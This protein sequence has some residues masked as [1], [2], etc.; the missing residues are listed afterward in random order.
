MVIKAREADLAFVHF[1]AEKCVMSVRADAKGNSFDY[2]V[3]SKGRMGATKAKLTRFFD[4][5]ADPKTPL[6]L[7]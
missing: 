3:Q 2:D 4:V 7:R 1:E 6:T 5:V